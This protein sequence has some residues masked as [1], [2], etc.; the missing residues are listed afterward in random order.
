LK[1]HAAC[2]A[3]RCETAKIAVSSFAS[4]RSSS[5]FLNGTIPDSV[6][7]SS[8]RIASSASSTTTPILATNSA[9]ERARR[10]LDNSQLPKSHTAIIVFPKLAY[11]SCKGATCT[12]GLRATRMLSFGLATALVD[13]S[14]IR[15]WEINRPMT[16]SPND[17]IRY[18]SISPSTISMDPIAATTSAKSRPS[19]IF[20]SVCRFAKQADRICT[21]YGFAVPSLTM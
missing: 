19:H 13:C 1:T 12:A 7:N 11:P 3:V 9:L 18:R 17:S 10:T 5:V 20:G 8:H 4:F 6:I 2:R 15:P 16:R 21:R 14:H